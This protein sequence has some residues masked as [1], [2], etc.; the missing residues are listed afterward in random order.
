MLQFI[1]CKHGVA[2]SA[3]V[4]YTRDPGF[5]SRQTIFARRKSLLGRQWQIEQ[6]T[7]FGNL[8]TNSFGIN[9]RSHI[10]VYHQRV[11]H[12]QTYERS[13]MLGHESIGL[14]RYY[15]YRLNKNH[16]LLHS[17]SSQIVQSLSFL[18]STSIQSSTET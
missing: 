16:V 6:Y 9:C 12:N 11:Y 3:L 10:T 8:S 5:N 2:N 13:T 1:E 14:R 15:S 4:C 17:K 7:C 18:T